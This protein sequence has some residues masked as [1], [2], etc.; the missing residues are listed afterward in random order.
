MS[1][2]VT[3]DEENFENIIIDLSY[4]FLE[5]AFIIDDLLEKR[6]KP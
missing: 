3:L 1:G 2:W 5:I 6:K 4:K